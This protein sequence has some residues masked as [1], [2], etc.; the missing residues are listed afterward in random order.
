MF[1]E[2]R[3]NNQ[4]HIFAQSPKSRQ[5]SEVDDRNHLEH[6]RYDPVQRDAEVADFKQKDKDVLVR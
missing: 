4:I 3:E 1:V 2:S 5:I 6:E